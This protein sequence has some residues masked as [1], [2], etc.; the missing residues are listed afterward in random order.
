MHLHADT[1]SFF[2]S[3]HIPSNAFTVGNLCG[4]AYGVS[5]V[6]LLEYQRAQV[7]E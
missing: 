6:E 3:S 2:F 7:R 4:T 1:K 5:H